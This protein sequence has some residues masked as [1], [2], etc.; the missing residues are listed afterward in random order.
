VGHVARA[1]FSEQ[2][3]DDALA[4]LVAALAEV[5]IADPPL[6]VGHVHR[7]PVVV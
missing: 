3:L 6:R 1:G 4:L 7:G 5:V 2:L